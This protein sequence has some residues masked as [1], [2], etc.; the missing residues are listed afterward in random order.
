MTSTSSQVGANI[1]LIYHFAMLQDKSRMES[2]KEAIELVVPI[3][4][5]VLELGGGTG[6][7]SYFAA[8]RAAKVYCV[9]RLRENVL[10]ARSL[11]AKN[12]NGER[13]EVICA[14]ALHYLP[15]EPVDVVICE[16]LHVGMI[17]EQQ[18]EV[19]ESFKK[20]YR[21]TFGGPLPRFIPE[22]FLQGIQPINYNFN[23][24][25][26]N[27]AVPLFQSPGVVDAACTELG[28][29]ALYQVAEYR[30]EVSRRISWKGSL[31]I[32]SSGEC[33]A[34][35]IILK[36]LV[37]ISPDQNISVSWHNQ[38]LIVPLPNS[39]FVQEGSSLEVSINYSSGCEVEELQN[40]IVVSHNQRPRLSDQ[41]ERTS[42]EPAELVDQGLSDEF[43]EKSIE[44]ISD[45][46]HKF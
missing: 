43:P 36:N 8:Q 15:P 10:V 46:R 35:R 23:F 11:L 19:I 20:R 7:L 42:Y 39:V 12:R 13:V 2:F 9:E 5:R 28:D 17:R 16:M 44:E 45:N 26:Y 21:A 33:N 37:A 4:S 14:D 6:A 34:M 31:P 40:S 18:I 41:I 24:F 38:Y 29:P 3:G 27:A 22:A 30:H 25:G 1:P 32:N